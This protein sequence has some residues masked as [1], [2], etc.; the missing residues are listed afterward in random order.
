MAGGAVLRD[1]GWQWCGVDLFEL[2][3]SVAVS[4]GPEARRDAGGQRPPS[5]IRQFILEM[6]AARPLWKVPW[7]HGELHKLGIRGD[8]DYHNKTRCEEEAAKGSVAPF[9]IDRIIAVHYCFN[10]KHRASTRGRS[11]PWLR[12]T[13]TDGLSAMGSW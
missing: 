10:C 11:T 4:A 3:W 7:S 8:P 9:P 5:N 12:Q 6:I 2:M 1:F 13:R